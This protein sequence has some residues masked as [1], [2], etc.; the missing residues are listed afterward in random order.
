MTLALTCAK[1]EAGRSSSADAQVVGHVAPDTVEHVSRPSGS[2]VAAV[3][4]VVQGNRVLYLV[5]AA[6]SLAAA[7]SAALHL[8]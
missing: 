2:K 7:I 6:L 5:V 3:S 4:R 8:V 1:Q